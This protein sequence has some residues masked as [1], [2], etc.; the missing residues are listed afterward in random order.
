MAQFRE[1]CQPSQDGDCTPGQSYCHG[2]V[3]SHN[4]S[5]IQYGNGDQSNHWNTPLDDRISSDQ[6]CHRHWL[7]EHSAIGR[8]D[9]TLLKK[10]IILDKLR[11]LPNKVLI[12]VQTKTMHYFQS[13]PPYQ[14]MRFSKSAQATNCPG[15][16]KRGF[17]YAWTHSEF[18]YSWSEAT[19]EPQLSVAS[20]VD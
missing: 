4:N 8:A 15:K 19:A 7:N 18:L 20:C 12:N 5:H 6:S 10:K 14:Q 17:P 13:F 16:C 2:K 9:Y 1:R 3:R 11:K